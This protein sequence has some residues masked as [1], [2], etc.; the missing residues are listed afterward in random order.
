MPSG[1]VVHA[2]ARWCSLYVPC[3]QGRQEACAPPTA[4]VPG[5][6]GA[7]SA[8]TACRPY[9]G[10]HRQ[11]VAFRRRPDSVYM[12]APHPVQYSVPV[13]GLYDPLGHD[14]HA[15]VLVSKN[16]CGGHLHRTLSGVAPCGHGRHMPPATENSVS[17]HTAHPLS[18][19]CV[20]ARHM[21]SAADTAPMLAV[22]WYSCAHGTHGSPPRQCL[23]VPVAH[24]WQVSPARKE[25]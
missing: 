17:V 12:C 18:A 9:P 6:H 3:A 14:L 22:V 21:Q 25:P 16:S 10:T 15:L 7:H 4:N 13:L 5:G 19:G 23:N 24:G 11:S 20:P 8:S 2:V 1:H